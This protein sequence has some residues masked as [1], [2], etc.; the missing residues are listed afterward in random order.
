MAS[1]IAARPRIGIGAVRAVG[2]ARALIAARE[3]GNPSCGR[4]RWDRPGRALGEVRRWSTDSGPKQIRGHRL[5]CEAPAV[6]PVGDP[7]DGEAVLEVQAPRHER[8]G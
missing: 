6:R 4:A 1:F 5:R 8:G 2:A 3:I 7:T